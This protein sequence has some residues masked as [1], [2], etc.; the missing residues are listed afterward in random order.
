MRP[1]RELPPVAL[2]GMPGTGSSAGG[3]ADVLAA[4]AE[5]LA[6]RR[7]GI[8]G[9]GRLRFA[10]YGRVSTEDR[11]DPVTSLAWQVDRAGATVAGEV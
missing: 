7:E 11:Q 8:S 1:Q 5:S 3:G 6:G 10:F 2:A 9:H 4:W